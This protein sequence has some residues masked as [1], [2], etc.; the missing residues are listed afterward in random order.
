MAIQQT[1]FV[2]KVLSGINTGASV[3]LKTG[4]LVIGRAMTSDIILHDENYF[5]LLFYQKVDP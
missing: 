1:S 2:L 4:S 5:V 3:R